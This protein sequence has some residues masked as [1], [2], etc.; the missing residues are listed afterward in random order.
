[1]DMIEHAIHCLGFQ[2]EGIARGVPIEPGAKELL[3]KGAKALHE[4]AARNGGYTEANLP[5]GGYPEAQREALRKVEKEIG[6][7]IFKEPI[8]R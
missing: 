4:A 7:P 3:L 1:M 8:H 2:A 5:G 6:I